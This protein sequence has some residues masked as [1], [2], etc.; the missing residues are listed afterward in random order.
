MQRAIR[1]DGFTLIE[2]MIAVAI[3][4]AVMASVYLLLQKGQTSF[5]R[6][7]E[8]ADMNQSARAGL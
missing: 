4:T 7:P 1:A 3:T 6:E 8:V 5:Q 2:M